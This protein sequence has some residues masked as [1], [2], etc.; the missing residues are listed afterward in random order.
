MLSSIYEHLVPVI[1]LLKQRIIFELISLKVWSADLAPPLEH[2]E[3]RRNTEHF[4]APR[5][6]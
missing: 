4:D 3:R 5:Y 2:G 6:R 1:I